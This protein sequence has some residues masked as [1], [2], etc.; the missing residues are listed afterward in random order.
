MTLS[1]GLT[2]PNLLEELKDYV[3]RFRDNDLD[4][5]L[6]RDCAWRAWHLCDY[7]FEE[8]GPNSQFPCPKKLKN[9]VKCVC[10]ELAYIQDIW[11][12]TK[13]VEITRYTPQVKA[14][15]YHGG[16]FSCDF[17]HDFDISHLRVVLADGQW[18]FFADVID[19]AVEFWSAFFKDHGIE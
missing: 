12:A 1:F 5:G 18:V 11:N 17:S 10:P 15:R 9:H 7:V 13:H 3:E 19:R 14:A 2:A 4:E 8:L 16:A 6:A